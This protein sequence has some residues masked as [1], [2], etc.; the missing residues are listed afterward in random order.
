MQLAEHFNSRGIIVVI[1]Q[2]RL[3]F[4]GFF[5]H[6]DG[7]KIGNLG[8]YDQ[9]MALKFVNKYI[10][11]F[12]GD[13]ERVTLW[14]NS[15]G[16]VSVH[17]HTLAPKSQS[18]FQ[19]A[20]QSSGS[21]YNLWSHTKNTYTVSKEVARNLKCTQTDSAELKKCLKDAPIF[22]IQYAIN[23]LTNG[24]TR[25][26]MRSG[27]DLFWWTP[28][29]DEE[30]FGDNLEGTTNEKIEKLTRDSKVKSVMYGL[31]KGE[32]LLFTL[33]TGNPVSS[34][35][36]TELG[37]TVK[38][39]DSYTEENFKN[40]LD[41]FVVTQ[42]TAGANLTIIKN[43]LQGFYLNK[44]EADGTE[45]KWYRRLTDIQTDSQFAGGVI[46]EISDKLI[47][48][49]EINNYIYMFNYYLTD[50]VPYFPYFKNQTNSV[51]R[52]FIN[53]LVDAMAKFVKHGDPAQ[54][55]G[56]AWPKVT[57]TTKIEYLMVGK[58]VE[59]GSSYYN[60]IAAL[61]KNIYASGYGKNMDS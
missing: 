34:V 50:C 14:G 41:S 21:L 49:P 39:Q 58:K 12:N 23:E 4:W 19:Y 51:E 45:T 9:R 38:Q 48:R 57:S 11:H 3:G 31:T 44:T 26:P 42:E 56:V 33:Q 32:G 60:N 59:T 46:Q 25:A 8:L 55:A 2:Y 17:A 24:S 27:M 40:H 53:K 61:W 5:S 47:W 52:D 6:D 37:R 30:F 16:S 43:M 28:V 29:M 54:A 13:P 1:V 15:A 35:F 22:K 10:H 36:A 7:E 20:I 18:Y